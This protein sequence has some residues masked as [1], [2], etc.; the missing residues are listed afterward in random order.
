[1]AFQISS[2]N[3]KIGRDSS[4]DIVLTD[5]TVSR[6]HAC[7]AHDGTQWNIEKIAANNSVTINRRDVQKGVIHNNDSIGLGP[8]SVLLFLVDSVAQYQPSPASQPEQ[9]ILFTE[10]A[11]QTGNSTG[12][13]SLEVSTN[14]SQDKQVM[15]LTKQVIKIGRDPSNDIF[16]NAPIV[17]AFHA[18][19]VR[20]G[21]DLIIVHPHPQAK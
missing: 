2:I 18:Q 14:I 7:I 4:N 6:F 10:R 16:I 11:P 17:S 19:I 9:D 15:Q 8:H 12:L 1:M 20:M 21:N 13:P 5:P 3:I